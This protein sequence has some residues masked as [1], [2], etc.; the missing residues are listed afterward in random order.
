MDNVTP[1]KKNK[2]VSKEAIQ[3]FNLGT[4]VDDL[5]LHYVKKD[6][7]PREI[8]V[9]LGHRIGELVR[10]LDDKKEVLV[11]VVETMNKRAGV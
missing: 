1:I 5:I 7:D 8:A 11:T 9:V 2:K 3:L 4:S 10:T 6:F